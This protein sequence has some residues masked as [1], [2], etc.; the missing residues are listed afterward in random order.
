MQSPCTARCLPTWT[1]VMHHSTCVICFRDAG[2]WTHAWCE[3]GCQ[4]HY[5]RAAIVLRDAWAGRTCRIWWLAAM[6]AAWLPGCVLGPLHALLGAAPSS[7]LLSHAA[8]TA[9]GGPVCA[10]AC[11]MD[12]LPASHSTDCAAF[13]VNSVCCKASYMCHRA[14]SRQCKADWAHWVRHQDPSVW[15]V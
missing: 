8:S 3:A 1:A 13:R 6:A 5:H 7:M 9:V 4:R 12:A 14:C 10:V 2:G 15:I 11:V